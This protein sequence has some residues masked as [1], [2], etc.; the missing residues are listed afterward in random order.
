MAEKRMFAK[1]IIDSDAF[2][3]MSLSTQALYFHLSMRADDDGFV[4]NP[5]K[6]QRMIGAGDDELKMLIAKKF[7]IPFESGVCVIKHWRI[8]NYIQN[9]RYKETVYKEEKA[10][11]ILKENKAY[12]YVDTPCIQTVS[13]V[14]TQIRLDK[15]REDKNRLEENRLEIE[16][17]KDICM[18]LSSTWTNNGY[19]TLN[20]T[21]LDKLLAD[22]EIYSIE[23]VT[24]AI[25]IG[26]QRSKRTYSYLKGIL[27]NWKTEGI[28]NQ[29]GKNEI[30]ERIEKGEDPF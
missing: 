28:K 11:L 1:T 24:K 30:Q 18:Q 23:W 5:K 14:E 2:L 16:D 26:N 17:K 10:H 3:D 27:E 15:N 8:H 29:K 12:K 25:E 22:V 7:I 9:D 6:I 21:L 20:K 19:G 4:N 13:K